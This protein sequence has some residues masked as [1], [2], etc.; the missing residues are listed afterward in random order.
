MLYI[1]FS[2]KPMINKAA[3]RNV[4]HP[5]AVKGRDQV[6]EGILCSIAQRLQ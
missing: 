3:L 4:P 6:K 1:T 5:A 2:S